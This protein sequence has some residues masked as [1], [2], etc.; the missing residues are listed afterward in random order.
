MCL[1]NIDNLLFVHLRNHG[2]NAGI[3]AFPC[4]Q[5]NFDIGVLTLGV[6]QPPFEQSL[7]MWD[8]FLA[9]GVH[10]NIF[11]IVAQMVNAKTRAELMESN[12]FTKHNT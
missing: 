3:Y 9:Y 8:F 7:V 4:N 6:C 5:S 1:Q 11:C 2:L 10:M 12:R